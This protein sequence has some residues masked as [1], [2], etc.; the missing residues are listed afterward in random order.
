MA[1]GK[2]IAIGAPSAAAKYQ[3][4]GFSAL[5]A[6]SIWGALA[7]EQIF[8]LG[9]PFAALVLYQAVVDYEK[10]YL[11]MWA[12]V[13]ISTEIFLPNGLGTDLPVE[14]LI[15]GL[16]LL[17]VVRLISRPETLKNGF[18]SH[19]I[20]VFLLLHLAWT[21]YATIISDNIGVSIKFLLAKIWYIVTFFYFSGHILRDEKAWKRVFWWFLIPF[22]LAVTKVVLH[23][24]V[25]SFGFRE[26]NTAT[27]PFFRNHVSYA[28]ILAL[29]L[30]IAWFAR[31]LYARFSIAWWIIWASMGILFFALLFAY[32]RAAYVALVLAI[33]AYWVVRFRLMRWGLAAASL[34]AV[35][36]VGYLSQ[37]NKF[38]DLAPTERTV[39]HEDFEDIVAATYK[40]EDV[41]T[42]ERYYRWVAAVRM[43][44]QDLWAGYG[45]GNFYGFYKGYTLNR[46]TTYVSD[47]PEQSGVHNYYLMLLV[48]QGLLGMLIF[49][50]LNFVILIY[51]ERLY[52]QLT[53]EKMRAILMAALLSTVV[54]FAFLL[55]NDMIETDKVGS[56]FFFNM[57]V[58]IAVGQ[59]EKKVVGSR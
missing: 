31:H 28:A 34:V 40:L 32:T 29:F 49:V 26:I 53:D 10:L 39:A 6:L 37:G 58:I 45:P 59:W 46:F 24:A 56:F 35:L 27:S 43:S 38:V 47:N 5:V 51:G 36:A 21:G 22:V 48:E 52:H 13:P 8:L 4:F 20:A 17:Y 50:A 14:P 44:Q 16:M 23:H 33:M 55:M 11:L 2:T 54:I 12:C 9:L 3:F 19:P 42:M 18:V 41:S 7:L 25:L 1:E 57:A 30:P 15:I